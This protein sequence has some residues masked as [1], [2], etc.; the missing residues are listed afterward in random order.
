LILV[1]KRREF[2]SKTTREIYNPQ[3]IPALSGT[4]RK[5]KYYRITENDGLRKE[6]SSP[7]LPLGETG[8]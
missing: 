3:T 4:F 7:S 2:R 1:T 6:P 5:K 8:G